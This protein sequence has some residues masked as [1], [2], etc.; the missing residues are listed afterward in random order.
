MATDEISIYHTGMRIDNNYY[1]L[2][3]QVSNKE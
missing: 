2:G 3:K 1:F